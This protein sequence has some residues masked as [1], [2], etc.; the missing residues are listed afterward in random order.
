MPFYCTNILLKVAV[1]RLPRDLYVSNIQ[2]EKKNTEKG[3]LRNTCITFGV[4]I[5]I[6]TLR[7]RRLQNFYPFNSVCVIVFFIR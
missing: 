2:K 5:I 6:K 1:F 3:H 4:Y 7:K